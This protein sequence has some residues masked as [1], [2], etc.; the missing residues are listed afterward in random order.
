MNRKSVV[1]LF[2]VTLLAITARGFS[3]TD[4]TRALYNF[5]LQHQGQQVG[6]G[7]CQSLVNE[8]LRAAGLPLTRYGR[9]VW[10]ISSSSRGVIVSGD[11][12]RVFAGDIVYFHD[13]F[14]DRFRYR[15]ET[16]RSTIPGHAQMNHVGIVES[17]TLDGVRYF[18]QNS[19]HQ[20][21]VKSDYFSFRDHLDAVDYVAIYRP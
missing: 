12:N 14:P 17:L 11:Y 20:Q 21:V 19:E 3:Q 2:A 16:G 5:C 1:V 10:R 15:G 9:E 4:A 13:I 6:D 18:D 8:A 7:I